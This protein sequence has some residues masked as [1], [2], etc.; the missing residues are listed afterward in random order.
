MAENV[1][2]SIL[3]NYA[4]APKK[5]GQSKQERKKHSS[6]HRDSRKRKKSSH[7][8]H[9]KKH[10]HGK[11]P[12]D[13]HKSSR[14]HRKSS[15]SELVSQ[16]N[17]FL[18]KL[19]HRTTLPGPPLEPKFLEYPHPEDHRTR[20]C[21]STL[22]LMHQ[23]ELFPDSGLAVPLGTFLMDPT[24][25][26]N[27]TLEPEDRRILEMLEDRWRKLGGEDDERQY[28]VK[29]SFLPEGT[30][31]VGAGKKKKARRGLSEKETLASLQHRKEVEDGEEL[32]DYEAMTK[33]A[34]MKTFDDV[35][36]VDNEEFPAFKHPDPKKAHLTIVSS[37]MLFP[38]DRLLE[39]EYSHVKFDEP[40]AK[41]VAKLPAYQEQVEAGDAEAPERGAKFAVLRRT[42]CGLGDK[43]TDFWLSQYAETEEL[44][45]EN[46]EDPPLKGLNWAT[47]WAPRAA[48]TRE[49]N[50]EADSGYFFA[51]TDAEIIYSKIKNRLDLYNRDAAAD[52][53]PKSHSHFKRLPGKL[54]LDL[55]QVDDQPYYGEDG[56]G[57]E[58]EV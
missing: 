19:K 54:K 14:H 28:D 43:A 18:T 57:Y 46:P 56:E 27:R 31:I 3:G 15:G 35:Y 32:S 24:I 23:Q 10:H 1:V 33:E 26:D 16:S 44:P 37:H 11:R 29:P 7:H 49:E 36:E 51:K 34:V 41:H 48:R 25:E 22:E 12:R 47:A 30:F 50:D 39:T 38:D 17:D 6:H 53:D 2:D 45:P 8:G 52:D 40:P 20:F 9:H 5:T 21:A 55:I 13:H 58:D 42:V 4:L